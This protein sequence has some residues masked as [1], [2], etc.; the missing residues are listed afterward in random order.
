MANSLAQDRFPSINTLR[1][2]SSIASA[3]KQTSGELRVHIDRNCRGDVMDRISGLFTALSMHKTEA[4][5]GVLIY[6]AIKD[7]K[8]AVI[9]DGG[10][11]EKVQEGFWQST[12]DAALP[13]FKSE[14]F[15][16]GLCSAIEACGKALSE[17]FPYCEDD[18]NELDNGIS[19]G[20]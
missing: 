8:F 2:E 17:H 13:H 12:Y 14:D 15:S 10:I 5:N 19:W 16:T 11:N 20:L 6:L 18:V 3:E 7:R 1:V 9:G 4:R